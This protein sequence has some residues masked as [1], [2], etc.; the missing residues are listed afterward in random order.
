MGRIKKKAG[1]KNGS[2]GKVLASQA[3]AY[4]LWLQNPHKKWSVLA[5]P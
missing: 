3:R 4:E 2:I 5:R 1:I